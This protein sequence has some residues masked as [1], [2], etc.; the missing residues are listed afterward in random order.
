MFFGRRRKPKR[1]LPPEPAIDQ[2]KITRVLE[3]KA[4]NSELAS[5]RIDEDLVFIVGQPMP[6][7]KIDR[8][9]EKELYGQ[10]SRAE[11]IELA[12]RMADG[13]SLADIGLAKPKSLDWIDL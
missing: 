10:L 6:W 11:R 13:T 3:E 2:N 7:R 4:R 1:P 9:K 12:R 8:S 5:E